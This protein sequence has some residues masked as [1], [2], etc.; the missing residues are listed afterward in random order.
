MV[1]DGVDALEASVVGIRLGFSVAR[2]AGDFCSIGVPGDQTH[3][4][5]NRPVRQWQAMEDGRSGLETQVPK[6]ESEKRKGKKLDP[7]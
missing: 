5:A 4:G 1:T 2:S 7:L 3:N 6:E